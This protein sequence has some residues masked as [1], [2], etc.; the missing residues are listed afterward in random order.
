MTQ[1]TALVTGGADRIGKAIALHLAGLGYHI[2]LHYNY[3]RDKAEATSR[4]I[5]AMG[6]GCELVGIDF[7]KEQDFNAI[8]GDLLTR[9][10]IEVLVNNASDYLPSHINEDGIGSLHHHMRVNF[11][12][13]YL[14][15]KA[16]AKLMP[17]GNIINIIDAKTEKNNTHYFDYLLTKKLLR[18]FT[19][20]SA[21]QLAPRFRVNAISPGLVEEAPPVAKG[22]GYVAMAAKLVPLQAAGTVG[23]IQKAVE[24]L[25]AM[26]SVTGQIIFIDGGNHL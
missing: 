10:R 16:F 6:V 15:T 21:Y 7:S 2:I 24:F 8:F 3:S 11:E 4:E 18:D 1:P 26:E 22:A 25:L 17:K 9:H 20:L 14:L 23:Q 19:L 13:A 12:A 5:R